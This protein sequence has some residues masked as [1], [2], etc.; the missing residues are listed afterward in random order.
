MFK[1]IILIV[2]TTRWRYTCDIF[3]PSV[4]HQVDRG[5]VTWHN[6][7]KGIRLLQPSWK[8]A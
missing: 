8:K 6:L 4:P 7:M 5:E 1:K 3:L 2:F